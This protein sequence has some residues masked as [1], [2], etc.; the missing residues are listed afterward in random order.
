MVLFLLCS[1]FVA[2]LFSL[3]FSSQSEPTGTE[4]AQGKGRGSVLLSVCLSVRACVRACVRVCTRVLFA[5]C[6]VEM[7]DT[8]PA[9][10]IARA[11]ARGCSE[12][13]LVPV[14]EFI[15]VLNAPPSQRNRGVECVL[16]ELKNPLTDRDLVSITSSLQQCNFITSLDLANNNIGPGGIEHLC[17]ALQESTNIK[18]L[19]LSNNNLQDEGVA[20]VAQFIRENNSLTTLVLEQVNVSAK[21]VAAVMA[22]LSENTSIMTLSLAGNQIPPKGGHA[23]AQVLRL[24]INLRSLGLADNQL[25][26]AG[27]VPIAAA[28]AAPS[29]KLT[30][31]DLQRNGINGMGAG[32]LGEALSRGAVL[33]TLNLAGN[34]GV[35]GD[36]LSNLVR[37]FSLSPSLQSVNLD[38]ISF[39]RD[40]GAALAETLGKNPPLKE[41]RIAGLAQLALAQDLAV[42]MGSNI[43]LVRLELS[44]KMARTEP[45]QRIDAICAVNRKIAGWESTPSALPQSSRPAAQARG[46]SN[47]N[48]SQRPALEDGGH[49]ATRN[50]GSQRPP[51]EKEALDRRMALRQKEYRDQ[52]QQQQ[53]SLHQPPSQH[54]QSQHQQQQQRQ[55]QQQQRQQQGQHHQAQDGLDG[56]IRDIQQ[57]AASGREPPR[58]FEDPYTNDNVR[59]PPQMERMFMQWMDSRQS[60]WEQRYEAQQER[61]AADIARHED[62]IARLGEQVSLC[63]A[64]PKSSCCH[65]SCRLI[66]HWRGWSHQQSH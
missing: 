38:G 32:S 40:S 7:A 21:G 48:G 18:H 55:P 45:G 36:G 13:G 2:V 57:F 35:G 44:S 29:C 11:Y 56:T 14:K 47:E 30:E 24:G 27:V 12:L 37:S 34:M 25:G 20:R 28:I 16:S 41:L 1:A 54:M 62:T 42:A 63:G 31:L 64:Y 23:I 51:Y 60:Q 26:D 17:A 66:V 5:A 58:G 19:S 53:Q 15:R 3:S 33:R 65:Q 39:T 50:V 4:K 59:V 49:G 8:N 52:L 9:T 46:E 10:Q 61:F 22:S 6:W 43:T